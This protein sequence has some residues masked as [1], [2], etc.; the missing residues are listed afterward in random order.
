M[1]SPKEYAQ[2]RNEAQ[3]L[4]ELAISQGLATRGQIEQALDLQK[5]EY[6]AGRGP[7]RGLGEILVQTGVLNEQGRMALLHVQARLAGGK[8]VA[9]APRGMRRRAR[10]PAWAWAIPL[11]VAIGSV[12]VF[13]VVTR[14]REAE[15]IAERQT[16]QQRMK[17]LVEQ[18]RRAYAAAE[19]DL[20]LERFRLAAAFAEEA[21]ASASAHRWDASEIEEQGKEARPVLA[22]LER[23]SQASARI[24]KATRDAMEAGDRDPA[25]SGSAQM[26]QALGLIDD[27][28][29]AS[30]PDDPYRPAVRRLRS[31]LEGRLETIASGRE[32]GK[33]ED[34]L[35]ALFRQATTALDSIREQ[36]RAL[37]TQG[38]S[39]D[40]F[41]SLS[42]L[43]VRTRIAC[44]SFFDQSSPADPRRGQVADVRR[45]L[46][47]LESACATRAKAALTGKDDVRQVAA[48]ATAGVVYV[49]VTLA[50]G[51]VIGWGSG[52]V[53]RSDGFVVTNRHVI[54]GA[55]SIH[56][57]WDE[58][59]NRGEV[60]A[61]LVA[62]SHE[63]DVALLRLPKDIYT[64]LPL[65]KEGPSRG[66][67]VLAMGFP[68][69]GETKGHPSLTLNPGIVSGVE[70][71]VSDLRDLM[72]TDAVLTP[73]NSGGPILD[74]DSGEVIS[75]VVA[76]FQG[77]LQGR[78]LGIPVSWVRTQFPDL[79]TDIGYISEVSPPILPKSHR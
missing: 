6:D 49:R 68:V 19:G 60:I 65:S 74:L 31:E 39:P 70:R 18:G 58:A 27:L 35:E 15:R 63:Q 77:D 55:E 61:T 17:D 12:I 37:D 41:A 28:E 32:K 64:A 30:P 66:G 22:Q 36:Y 75:I 13:Q 29:K 23:T 5:R 20:A 45:R 76:G 47:E 46:V 54:A 40:G 56:V 67:K 72:E 51:R 25:G 33:T 8:P 21:A 38:G 44:D 16:F 59:C 42:E 11:A 24:G 10:V 69:V 2:A 53:V 57:G 78:N 43:I 71:K 26:Q 4:G 52:F 62:W 1:G 79:A 50:G 48:K 9:G 7:I 3:R 73:G 14:T 34:R